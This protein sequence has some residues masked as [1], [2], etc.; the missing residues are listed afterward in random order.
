MSLR[1]VASLSPSAFM[2]C[3][4]TALVISFYNIVLFTQFLVTL[5]TIGYKECL[6]VERRT[7]NG[8]SFITGESIS[9][10]H[11]EVQ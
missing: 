10:R 2:A 5:Y 9:E 7:T 8:F 1:A 6:R 11:C 4:A 3:S